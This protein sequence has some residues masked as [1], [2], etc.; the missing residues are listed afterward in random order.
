MQLTFKNYVSLF[1]AR[2][3]NIEYKE[4]KVK[5]KI[6]R[7][8]VELEGSQS[9][10]ITKLAKTYMALDRACK[11]LN[12]RRNANNEALTDT[13]IGFFDEA[14][15]AAYTR[16][17]NTVSFTLTVAKQAEAKDKT[18][19]DYEKICE[20]LKTLIDKE[21]IDKIKEIEQKYTVVTKADPKA[22]V[23]KPGLKV[24]VKEGLIDDIGSKLKQMLTMFLASIKQWAK[25]YDK[26]LTELSKRLNNEM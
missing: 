24:D 23:K 19:I 1:E 12:E 11:T 4:V 16:V 5:D 13:V 26:K 18:A 8:I 25:D 3:E 21:L 15:D 22:P 9:G 7:V 17:I 2:R 14:T 6:A 20:E 10:A